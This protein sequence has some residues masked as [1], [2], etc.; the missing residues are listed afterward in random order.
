MSNPPPPPTP[1]TP[2][3]GPDATS[4]ASSTPS[5]P[6]PSGPQAGRV[7]ATTGQLTS[8]LE[9]VGLSTDEATLESLLLAAD[10]RGYLEWTA[11]TRSGEYVWDLTD[12][13]DR[14]ADAIA[15]AL[16]EWL[17][18]RLGLDGGLERAD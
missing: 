1:P 15:S 2:S 3:I 16:L 10:R 13:P 14:L 8:A 6:P 12:A 4:P 18:T 17:A 7:L 5:S 11:L 9:D